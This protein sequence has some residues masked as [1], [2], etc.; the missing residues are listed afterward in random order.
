MGNTWRSSPWRETNGKMAY[1]GG[2]RRSAVATACE[3]RG[4]RCGTRES[5]GAAAGAL[6]R[7]L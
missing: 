5:E 3:G 6:G 1:G 2:L 7:F 4:G